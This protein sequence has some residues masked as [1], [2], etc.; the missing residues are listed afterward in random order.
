MKKWKTALR[1]LIVAVAISAAA[2]VGVRLGIDVGRAQYHNT[3]VREIQILASDLVRESEKENFGE[4]RFLS[5]KLQ[6]LSLAAGDDAKVSKVLAAKDPNDIEDSGV[7]L[8]TTCTVAKPPI[9][10]IVTVSVDERFSIDGV[11]FSEA[12]IT[13]VCKEITA[14]DENAMLSVRF[15][16]DVDTATIRK[17][18][19]AAS[20]G[21]LTDVTFGTFS[22]AQA[23]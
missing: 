2:I 9:R 20:D 21:G 8:A 3:Y 1:L 12:Q 10:L 18:V 15:R 11:E 14:R 22:D 19:A 17:V 6:A 23:N 4:S 5:E 7:F 13:V 16:K